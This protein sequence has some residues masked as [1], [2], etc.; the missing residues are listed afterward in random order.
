METAAQKQR[1]SAKVPTSPLKRI[2]A[3]VGNPNCGKTTIFNALTGLNQRVGNWPG[4]TVDKKSGRFRHDGQ[5]YEL[6][7]LPGIYSLS[8]LSQDE[9]VAR[10]YIL[11]GEAGLVVNIVDASNPDRN[12]YLTS[13]LL[14]MGVPVVVALNMVDAAEE[15]GISVD[16]ARL[17]S[18]LGCP[19][20]PMVASRGEGIEE[21]KAAIA[22]GFTTGGASVPSAK[23]RF[24]AELDAAIRRVAESTGTQARELGYDPVWFAM[25]LL[26]HDQEL[27]KRLDGAALTSL[28]EERKR[29]ADALGD[30]PDIVIADAHYRFVSELSAAAITRK[31]STRKTLSDKIDSLVLN[32]FLG[33]PLFLGV[34][35]L[36]FLFTIKLGGAF[37]DFFD[38]AAGALFV[39]GFG[40]LLGAVGSP[41]W[42]T[43]LLASGVGRALQTMATFIPT[44]GFMFIFLSMLEDSGYMARAAYVMDRGMRAI[45]LPGKAFIPLLVG[46]GCNVPAIMSA[47]TMSDERD[48]IMTVMMTPFMSCGARLPVYALF[49]AAFFPT[50]GQNLIF[51]LYL[52]GIA[53]AIMTGFILKKTLLKGEPSPF[54]MEMP[55]YHLPTLKGVILRVGD[56]LG[57]FLLK[58]GK[59]L[60]P[61]IVVLG[62]M[63]S[64][65]TDGSFGNEENE[66]SVLVATGKA[67]VP[68]L[69]PFGIQEKNWPAAVG[70]FAGVFAKEAVVGT[71]NNFYAAKEAKAAVDGGGERFSLLA[72]LGEA[73]ATIPENL[74]GIA[75]SLFDPLGINV[76]DLSDRGAVA[77]EQ[78]VS[79]SIYGSMV[80]R[81]DGRVGAFAYLVFIL[82]YFPCV[83]SIGVIY[84][85][86]NLAW[87]LFS[88]VWTT[89]LAYVFAVLSYQI[90]TWGAHPGS[91]AAWVAAMLLVFAVA[92]TLMYL[93]G[94]GAFGRKGKILEEA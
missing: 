34:M 65:G 36:M 45:G 43:A 75:G 91:S 41:G 2:V 35:Y 27:E 8:S 16:P 17:S 37:I 20:I 59:V 28:F 86:T 46:F 1:V 38:I 92:V 77:K 14:E 68:V 87:T 74:A 80:N 60:V 67:I 56:R 53:V 73:V 90:G 24:P 48:R 40:R 62:F 51:L 15:Q 25:K 63:S 31:E 83:A 32:R 5:E 78:G 72:K 71:L 12:L 39:D 18:L 70:L 26:E 22:K 69:Q 82:L 33:I 21:L 81:F 42:L 88:V 50:G 58:A 76:G 57:S 44:I 55:P 79:A 19:V 85:E 49:A 64:I 9:E 10:S 84:R 13:R 23:V 61:V 94:N 89:G 11:S 47:R 4:V 66:N 30:D 52:M 7:D 3:V 6:V 93:A 29:V 54:I